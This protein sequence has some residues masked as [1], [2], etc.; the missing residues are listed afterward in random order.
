MAIF[1][2]IQDYFSRHN[3]KKI[4]DF[5]ISLPEYEEVKTVTELYEK[6]IKPTLI[7][8]EYAIA[9]H[10]MLVEYIDRSDAVFL[11]RK[12]EGGNNK[13]WEQR[14]LRPYKNRR[15]AKTVMADGCSYVFA[16]NFEVHEIYNMAHK[17]IVPTAEEFAKLL[18]DNMY[19]MHYDNGKDSEEALI[20]NKNQFLGHPKGTGIL[21]G[22]GWYLAH[23]ASLKENNHRSD[24]F[25]LP[26]ALSD[27][28]F[29][30]GVVADWIENEDHVRRLPDI[31][32]DEEKNI[33]KAH[34]LRFCDPLNYFLV[35]KSGNSNYLIGE[36]P[37]VINYVRQQF[38]TRYGQENM[39]QFNKLAMVNNV[40]SSFID[41][42]PKPL[43]YGTSFKKEKN[44]DNKPTGKSK[45]SRYLFNGEQTAL[46]RIVLS[47]V[48]LYVEKHPDINYEGLCRVFP[49]DLQGSYGVIKNLSEVPDKD[50]SRFLTDSPIVLRD[51]TTVV[52]CREWGAANTKKNFLKFIQKMKDLGYGDMITEV[53]TLIFSKSKYVMATQCPKALW[54][55][56]NKP[57]IIDESPAS[58]ERIAV[59]NEVGILAQKRFDGCVVVPFNKNNLGSM[60]TRTNELLEEGQEYIAEASFAVDNLF[61]SV[62]ILHHLG[63]KKVDI[64]EVKSTAKIKDHY[65]DDVAF[66][67]FVVE[68]CGFEVNR[69]YLMHLNN[70][71]VRHGE[72]DL[73]D[74][75][76]VVDFTEQAKTKHDEVEAN[77]G[78]FTEYMKQKDE[79]PDII[80]EQCK[81]DGVMCDCW[82]YCT[83][84]LPQPNVF[85][86]AGKPPN[87]KEKIKY[88]HQG[89]IDFNQLYKADVKKL[90]IEYE[91]FDKAPHIEKEE[92]Q[93]FL[94]GLSYP[95]YFLDFES[96]QMAVPQ[97]DNAKP[98]A[99]IV[100]QYSL[101][102]IEQE[103]GKLKHKECLAY[104]GEDPRR[105]IAEQL[106]MDIPLNGCTLAYHKSFE[107]RRIKELAEL[108]P[109]LA[110]HLMNIHDHIQDLEVPFHNE[111]YYVKEM[112]GRSSIKLVLPALFPDDPAL[113]YH[114][115]E[116]I[117]N[118]TEASNAF[119]AMA[120]MSP[121][122][123][124]K[125]RGYLLKYC[126][127][128]TFAMV[129]VWDKL[130]E[131]VNI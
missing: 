46:G 105:G 61:C 89:I 31:W 108:F 80:D 73:Q 62:D 53:S 33:V 117:H 35:P 90:Q 51:N 7:D 69:V 129:K 47:V 98:Y 29:P 93:K 59:G 52:I 57:E 72:L 8:S 79:S 123:L 22:K 102:Y 20:A 130:R 40:S 42:L 32:T 87:W 13:N 78:I 50:K 30:R 5:E 101:H 36:N 54:L 82:K 119:L 107:Q 37:D 92:I 12:Y 77:L 113:D 39:Q 124:E 94:A 10:K 120:D 23:I 71:Y 38:Y 6:C 121:E 34:F 18:N 67:C 118:G 48:G 126:G 65:Y 25:Y 43:K 44:N 115:L 85:D 84:H 109:D 103:G 26:E 41:E 74:L 63:G 14:G 56:T 114:N 4:I 58:E 11:I 97:Y 91:L 70:D 75:F 66:Q 111:N 21:N 64:Y 9:W 100:F 104:P 112:Q 3:E 106:C 76:T 99:Q 96:C 55:K 24:D 2:G 131:A 45:T 19:P 17:G 128:D 110:E 122:E 68:K 125:Y 127:L 116:G 60:V 27:K 95:L 49:K 16:S 28:L 15:A 83:G 88:Y 1:T 86:V 81:R